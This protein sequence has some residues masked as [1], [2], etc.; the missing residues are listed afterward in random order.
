MIFVDAKEIHRDPKSTAKKRNR[1]IYKNAFS[2]GKKIGWACRH[3]AI[4]KGE[5]QLDTVMSKL[6]GQISRERL[7][8]EIR[9]LTW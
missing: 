6:R 4:V 9:S 7:L 8:D 1:Y 5:G 2:K 3:D